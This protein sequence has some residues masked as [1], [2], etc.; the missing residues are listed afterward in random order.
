LPLV[1]WK[2]GTGNNFL[3]T[4][5]VFTDASGCN[6]Y[7]FFRTGILWICTLKEQKN[8]KKEEKKKKT[9]KKEKKKKKKEKKIKEKKKKKKIIKLDM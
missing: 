8:K 7:P 2:S 6:N 5:V 4:F 3:R 1:P 9:R